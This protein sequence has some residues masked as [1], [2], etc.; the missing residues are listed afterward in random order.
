VSAKFFQ[1]LNKLFTIN[2]FSLNPNL[3]WQYTKV[4]FFNLCKCAILN[5]AFFYRRARVS[6]L[7]TPEIDFRRGPQFAL[8]YD[9]SLI[10]VDYARPIFS[11]REISP[12]RIEK[13]QTDGRVTSDLITVG[14]GDRKERCA[15]LYLRIIELRVYNIQP[16]IFNRQSLCNRCCCCC[17]QESQTFLA[18]R[19]KADT[20]VMT[21]DRFMP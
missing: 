8:N 3:N 10:K 12:E 7:L 19:N 4:K 14:Q 5:F 15:H 9:K 18:L 13:V 6:Q 17:T 21:I 20:F 2:Y 1:V 11:L 16:I